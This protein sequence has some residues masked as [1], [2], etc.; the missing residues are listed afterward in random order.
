MMSMVGVADGWLVSMMS[1]RGFG[2]GVA[3]MATEIVEQS[4][5]LSSST[6]RG[7]PV[8]NIAYLMSWSRE[9]LDSPMG[10][11]RRRWSSSLLQKYIF[12]MLPF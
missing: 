9:H 5:F 8:I 11:R 3:G 10:M 7:E 1:T 2:A 4:S 6:V 12:N